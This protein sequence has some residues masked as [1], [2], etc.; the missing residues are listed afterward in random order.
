MY[1][2]IYSCYIIILLLYVGTQEVK[3][4][5]LLGYVLVYC[6]DS[7]KLRL[8]KLLLLFIIHL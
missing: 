1:R 3:D 8:L 4:L 7:R 6:H 2:I 5:I